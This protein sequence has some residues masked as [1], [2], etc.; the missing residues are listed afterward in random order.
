MAEGTLYTVQRGDSY[1]SLACRFN[2]TIDAIVA[3]NPD[4]APGRLRVGQI[5]CIPVAVLP[6]SSMN[7]LICQVSP[8][9]TLQRHFVTP[10]EAFMRTKVVGDCVRKELRRKARKHRTA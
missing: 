7:K 5:I 8:T 9:T 4:V 6:E 3:A 1:F 10:V 2:L